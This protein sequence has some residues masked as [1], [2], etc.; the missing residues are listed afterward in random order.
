MPAAAR[1]SPYWPLAL[2]A[3]MPCTNSVSPTTLNSSGP[4]A[5]YIDVH[6]TNTVWRT[7][8]AARVRDEL[9]EEVAVA[10]PIPEVMVRIDDRKPRLERRLFGQAQPVLGL[11]ALRRRLGRRVIGPAVHD[12]GGGETP[13]GVPP[14]TTEKTSAGDVAV[15]ALLK[16]DRRLLR[17]T[18]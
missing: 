8:C 13:D 17:R 5:R 2:T 14:G 7:L 3:A 11:G 10:R 4:V 12:S 9:L 16:R 1:I 18:R 15:P 6:S